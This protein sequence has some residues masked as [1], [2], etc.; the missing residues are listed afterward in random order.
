MCIITLNA[1]SGFQIANYIKTK[2]TK[3]LNSKRLMVNK[4]K[5]IVS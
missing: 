3:V 5:Y 1:L 2:E 4:N